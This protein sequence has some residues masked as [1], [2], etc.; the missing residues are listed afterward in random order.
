MAQDADRQE[1]EVVVAG[2]LCL[3]II[4]WIPEA[5]GAD[6]AGYTILPGR[7]L[8]I[9][10]ATLSTGGAVPNTGINLHR[11]GIRCHLMCRVG[12]D[13][14]GRVTLD[15]IGSHSPGLAR[16][17]TP[18]PGE[19][20]SYTVVIDPA[21]ADRT[22]LHYPGPN[23]TFDPQDIHYGLVS[24]ARVF[25]FGYPPLMDRLIAD[26]GRGL[27][28][29]FRRAK[30]TGA[31]T[32]LDLSMPDLAGPSAQA[33]WRSILSRTLPH[34]DLF[35]PSVQ[36][37]LFMLRRERFETLSAHA[38]AADP[39]QAVAVDEIVDLAEEALSMGAKV[40]L[41]K[42]GTRGAYL[43]TGASLSGLGRGAPEDLAPWRDRQMWAPCFKPNDVT[44][45]VGTGDAAIA[46]FLAAL[47][48]AAPPARALTVAVAAGASCVEEAG[49]LAGVESWEKTLARID[50]GWSRLPL[51]IQRPGWT[52]DGRSA[53]W[54]GPSD[55]AR[56]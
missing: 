21:G 24:R 18:A 3:D 22:F 46:G 15:L 2:H 56:K 28:D 54:R 23:R 9:G 11:L 41:L 13:V 30:E 10:P 17:I 53:V 37:L 52:W 51:Q 47:L 31:T 44:S 43:R 45:T 50:A 25:H 36:E 8:T 38:S 27:A 39:M 29:M 4:P 12:D 6:P 40:V 55:R 7:S 32:S 14:L 1:I 5:M 49:S 19:A 42:L 16:G 48:R 35:L 20:S 34:V 33:N 26:G